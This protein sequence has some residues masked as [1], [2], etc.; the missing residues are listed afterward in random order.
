MT[1]WRIGAVV[2]NAEIIKLVAEVKAHVDS[3]AFQAIQIAGIK[4]LQQGEQSIKK[5]CQEYQKRRDFMT[6]ELKKLGF[7]VPE[8]KATFYLFIPVPKGYTST[9]FCMKLIEE[10]AVIVTPG[11]GFGPNGEGYFR[12]ALTLGEQRLQ[13]AVKRI[14]A[15]LKK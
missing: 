8:V 5:N 13:E 1:G 3:G 14:A 12:I 7:D 4:A 2:G 9:D 10:A 15:V 11:N 6:K